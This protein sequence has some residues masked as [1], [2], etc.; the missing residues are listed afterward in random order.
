MTMRRTIED[1]MARIR[2]KIRSL[3]RPSTLVAAAAGA[4]AAMP[5]RAAYWE[6]YFQPPVTG[7]SRIIT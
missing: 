3:Q 2:P 5:A 1:S 6:W 7:N 4:L